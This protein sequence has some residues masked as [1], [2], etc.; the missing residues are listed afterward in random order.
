MNEDTSF[1]LAALQLLKA[2][3]N[4]GKNNILDIYIF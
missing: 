1:Q 3:L 4:N 2:L